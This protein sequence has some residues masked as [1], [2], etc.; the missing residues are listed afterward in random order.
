MIVWPEAERLSVDTVGG[1]A[2]SLARLD[3]AGA[4][5]VPRWFAVSA[6]VFDAAI[7]RA[8]VR[9]D[10]DAAL[11]ALSAAPA[12]DAAAVDACAA[13]LAE[14]LARLRLD[15]ATARAI[16]VAYAALGGGE[17]AVRSSAVDEDGAERS[18]AGCLGTSLCVSGADAVRAAVVDCWRSALSARSLAYRAARGALCD[19]VRV[20]VVVQRMIDG[21]V[22]GVLFTADP[23]TGERDRAVVSA[24]WGLGEGVVSGRL[25]CDSYAVARDGTVV[26]RDVADKAQAVVRAPGGGTH[27]VDVAPERRSA[28]C[29][30]DD[31]LA[32][33]A[34]LGRRVE[35]A[36]GAPVDIEWTWSADGPWLLQ[37]RPITTVPPPA[38]RGAGRERLWDNSN[39]IESY[40]GVTTPLTYSFARRAYAMVYRQAFELLGTPRAELDAHARTFE[41][42]IG[43]LRGRVYYN[44][45][46]WYALLRLLPGYKFNAEFME[47]MMGVSERADFAPAPR[48]SAARRWGVELPRALSS[49]AVLAARFARAEA[50]V[51]EFFRYFDR[52]HAELTAVALDALDFDGL[53]DLYL[54]AER[55]LMAH[56]QAPI[57]NDILAMVFFG[58]LRKALAAWGAEDDNL[59]ND[60][61]CG[62]GGLLSAEPTRDLL[63]L[64]EDVRRDPDACA[65]LT[66]ETAAGARA[67]VEADDRFGWLRVRIAA[68]VERYGDRCVDE[69]KL[70]Q[71]T[72]RDD[73]TFVYATLQSYLAAPP[74]TVAELDEREA[75]IRRDAE[76]RAFAL[77]GRSAVRRRTLAWLVDRARR[78]VRHRENLRFCRTRAFALVRSIVVAMG[79]RLAAAGVIDRRDDVFYLE[80]DE[81]IAFARGTATTTD[82]RGLAGVRRREFDAHRAASAPPERLRTRGAVYLDRA[83]LAPAVARADAVAAGDAIVGVGASPGVA[84]APVRL[85]RDPRGA[86]IAGDVLV[87]NRTDPGWVP[88]FPS[89][90]AV[91][92]ERGSVLSHS[93]IVAR[94]LGIP[95]VVGARDALARLRDGQL[96]EVDGTAGRVTA[97]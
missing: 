76:R 54:E 27:E 96:V 84:R 28:P 20:A 30:S 33:L 40:D 34:A 3:R 9:A 45:E 35:A 56:W 43:L 93:A 42:M 50:L 88:L 79:E 22:S 14:P 25:A 39:I 58:A 75:D 6:D 85:V 89:A 94:E 18:F 83:A 67:A 46:S 64:A 1:K 82:L 87:A 72:L 8:G 77:V 37:A 69:L 55:R 15:D 62:T 74:V 68:H 7:D 48:P 65:L 91:V 47:Q 13:A 51:A 80:I 11:A 53:A 19:P 31:Q 38:R 73:P 71:P 44:L 36:W 5:R 23:T 95:C 26:D 29:L 32:A 24:T 61:L 78:H 49:A 17:V 70:E 60:L 66:R 16:A 10:I 90:A 4:G 2:Y 12:A 97:L 63:A 59:H 41:Q 57:V 86:R 81:L 21:D 52:T 92:V